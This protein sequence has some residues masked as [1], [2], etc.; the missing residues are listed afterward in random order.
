MPHASSVPV[1]SDTRVRDL[2][3]FCSV[4]V[5]EPSVLQTARDVEIWRGIVEASVEHGLVGPLYLSTAECETI[6]SEILD[7]LRSAYIAQAARNFQITSALAEVLNAFR[8]SRIDIL[9]LK[10]P[11]VAL[12]AFDRIAIREFTDLDLLIRPNDLL[13]ARDIL[14]S[15]GYSQYGDCLP[16]RLGEKDVLFTRETDDLLV[17][18]HWAVTPRSLHF[19]IDL[20]EIW[21]RRQL[22]QIQTTAI[23]TLGLEDTILTLCIHGSKHGWHC[24]KWVHDVASLI[25]RKRDEIDWSLLLQRSKSAGCQRTLL[26][27]LRLAVDLFNAIVPAELPIHLIDTALVRR[28]ARMASEPLLANSAMTQRDSSRFQIEGHD[29]VLDRFFVAVSMPVPE[30]PRLLPAAVSPITSGP[31]RFLTRPIRL[32]KIYGLSWFRSVVFGH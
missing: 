8:E 24:L 27:S 20:S 18:L 5:G 31:L 28:L 3:S 21:N 22:L 23:P 25:T 30:L 19:P 9:V 6:P 1:C 14:T 16:T 4:S 26:V 2:A 11:A 32:V 10:G 13:I 7:T 17:E 29:R 12:L 15:L